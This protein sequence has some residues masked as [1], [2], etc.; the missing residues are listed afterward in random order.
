[1][2]GAIEFTVLCVPSSQWEMSINGG[3]GTHDNVGY[4]IWKTSRSPYTVILTLSS[5]TNLASACA[6]WLIARTSASEY[7]LFGGREIIGQFLECQFPGFQS[8]FSVLSC[9]P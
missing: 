8:Y 7:G 3:K 4:L 6:R 2:R 9:G 1:M 5:D